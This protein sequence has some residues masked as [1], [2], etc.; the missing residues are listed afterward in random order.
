MQKRIPYRNKR[1]LEAANGEQCTLQGPNCNG[2]TD[3]TV[4]CHLNE[5]YA[6]KGMR[7]KADDC[8]G[9]FGCFGCHAD[10]DSNNLDDADFYVLRA[11][12]RTIRRLLDKGI[13]K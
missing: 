5:A 12:T 11:V 9:F 7:Q 1:I 3:T 8:A 2:R 10:Y 6:G 4:F 13:I